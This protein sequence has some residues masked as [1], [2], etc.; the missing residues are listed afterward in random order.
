MTNGH[1]YSYAMNNYWHTNYMAGQ[2]GDLHLPLL[3]H[4]PGEGGQRGL[5]PIRL[6]GVQ[7]AW[8]AVVVKANPQRPLPAAPRPACSPSPSRT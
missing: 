5:G 8:Q 4:Q 7:S 3:D 2:G 1:L 6:G